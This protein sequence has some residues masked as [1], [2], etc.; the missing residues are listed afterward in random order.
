MVNLHRFK[1][2][3]FEYFCIVKYK[4]NVSRLPKYIGMSLFFTANFEGIYA[5]IHEGAFKGA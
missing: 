2:M 5:Y 1:K 3:L 4:R